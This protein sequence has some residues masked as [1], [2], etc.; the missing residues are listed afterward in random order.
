MKIKE[1][2]KT[3][4]GVVSILAAL[5]ILAFLAIAVYDWGRE[6]SINS[7][8]NTRTT[9]AT[10]Q[11]GIA[12]QSTANANVSQATRQSEDT[13]REKVIEPRRRDDTAK[14]ADARQR[15]ARAKQ[16]YENSRTSNFNRTVSDADLHRSNCDELSNLFPGEQFADCQ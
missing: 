16:N 2:C 1:F 12:E 11:I 13:R 4:T 15:T 14:S 8:V 6:K 10:R 3:P 7:Q 9:E 5:F